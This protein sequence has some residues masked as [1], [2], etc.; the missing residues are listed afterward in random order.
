MQYNLILV[1]HFCYFIFHTV[2]S[3]WY[4]LRFIYFIHLTCTEFFDFRSIFFL[5]ANGIFVSLIHSFV[6]LPWYSASISYRFRIVLETKIGN[7]AFPFD[8]FPSFCSYLHWMYLEQLNWKSL[9]AWVQWRAIG[10]TICS[11]S[12]ENIHSS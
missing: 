8:F 1:S 2:H 7:N 9:V 4:F 3:E 6:L 10:C 11:Y 5:I 12:K